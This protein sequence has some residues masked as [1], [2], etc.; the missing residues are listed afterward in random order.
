M[1]CGLLAGRG[2]LHAGGAAACTDLVP[3]RYAL[4]RTV[5]GADPPRP[6]LS[7]MTLRRRAY[8]LVQQR[9]SRISWRRLKRHMFGRRR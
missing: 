3:Q 9:R 8:R 2:R 5:V 1:S 4:V 7:K 6:A